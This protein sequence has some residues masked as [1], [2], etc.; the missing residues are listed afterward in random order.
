ML[1]ITLISQCF[2]AFEHKPY[3][4][5]RMSTGRSIEL[6]IV[7][8]LDI[9]TH[10]ALVMQSNKTAEVSWGRLFNQPDLQYGYG[11]GTLHLKNVNIGIV[12][13]TFG[14]PICRE[15]ILGISFGHAWNEKLVVGASINLYQLYIKHYGSDITAGLNLSWR[16]QIMDGLYWT[17]ALQNINAPT[18]GEDKESLSQ[19]MITGISKELYEGLF[20]SI[21]WMHE[22]DYQKRFSFGVIYFPIDGLGI[23]SGFCSDP[24][25]LTCG[26]VFNRHELYIEYAAALNQNINQLSHQVSVGMSL[27]H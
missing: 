22:L 4:T 6:P 5:M 21:Q 12:G 11:A 17:T 26:V 15:T 10:P 13:G 24:A 1:W 14:N 2:G 9:L 7:H 27:H 16:F 25:E 8:P 23:S 3:S 19:G 20:A 18:V